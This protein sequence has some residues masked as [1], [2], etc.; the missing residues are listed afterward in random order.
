VQ[1]DRLGRIAHEA[2]ERGKHL[3]L[4]RLRVI[5]FDAFNH[6]VSILLRIARGIVIPPD[7]AREAL[8]QLR[9]RRTP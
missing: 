7:E 4:G 8:A 3:Q 1:V 2:A 5:D 9:R 6:V